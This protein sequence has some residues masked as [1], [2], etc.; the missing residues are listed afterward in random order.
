MPGSLEREHPIPKLFATL[1]SARNDEADSRRLT[2]S[3]RWR[4]LSPAASRSD[5]AFEPVLSSRSTMK[6]IL[7][8]TRNV[9]ISSSSTMHSAF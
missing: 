5:L 9:V 4:G 6:L 7:P 2:R 1:R 8:F 3:Q